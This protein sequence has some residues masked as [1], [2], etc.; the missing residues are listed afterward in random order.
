MKQEHKDLSP[1]D[2]ALLSWYKLD[3]PLY[4]D[5]EHPT[6]KLAGEIGELL[7]LYGKHKYKPGVDWMDCKYCGYGN[8]DDYHTQDID[9]VC[10]TSNETYTPLVLDELGDIWY[11]LRIL[12]W[13]EDITL[14]LSDV[15]YGHKHI[16]CIKEM[17]Q[18]A[19]YLFYT[20]N[21]KHNLQMIYYYL[22]ILLTNLDCTI[23][24][25]TELNYQ[26]LNSE[27][28]NRGWEDTR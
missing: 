14:S 3:N 11:Y 25:L 21:N 26:K 19:G 18:Y 8:I 24:Q 9:R 22:N 10:L 28:T 17:Y 13:I 15:W 5:P 16:D 27:P 6:F 23:E 4:R 20:D 1:I 12:A 7:D 2:L